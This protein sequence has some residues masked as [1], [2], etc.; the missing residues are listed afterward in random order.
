MPKPPHAAPHHKSY[1]VSSHVLHS[2]HPGPKHKPCHP[3]SPKAPGEG[4]APASLRRA[5]SGGAVAARLRH[6]RAEQG[7]HIPGRQRPRDALRHTSRIQ[8][9]QRG[10]AGPNLLLNPPQHPSGTGR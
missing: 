5:P 9:A 7:G 2:P 3:G 1:P 8:M 10:V 6:S 4:P